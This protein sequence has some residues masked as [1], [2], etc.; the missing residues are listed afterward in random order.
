MIYNKNGRTKKKSRRHQA[1]RD[2]AHE[3]RAIAEEEVIV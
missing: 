2:A 3:T 1:T